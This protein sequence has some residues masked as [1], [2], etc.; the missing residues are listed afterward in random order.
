MIIIAVLALLVIGVGGLA[1][2]SFMNYSD[3]KNNVDAKIDKAVTLS[4][5]EQGDKL[6]KQF[7]E[8]EKKPNRTF[9]GP[10]D[11]GSLQFSYPKTW[12]AYVESDGVGSQ[13]FKAYLNPMTVPPVGDESQRFAVRVTITGEKYE[14]V[15]AG[16]QDLVKEGDLKSSTVKASGVD[17]TRLDGAFSEDLRGA[18]VIYKIRDKTAIIQTDANTFKPDFEKIIA[19]IKFKQ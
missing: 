2:W 7:E 4:E 11:Y 17:G 12:S 14:D 15:I 16:Y 8:A 3:Q 1:V 6:A 18:A 13:E 9:S 5:K 10:A 19:T